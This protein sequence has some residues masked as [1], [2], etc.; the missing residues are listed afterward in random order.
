MTLIIHVLASANQLK[1]LFWYSVAMQFKSEVE[2]SAGYFPKST[3]CR[4]LRCVNTTLERK[5]CFI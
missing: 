3:K 2:R 1:R 4:V 5:K